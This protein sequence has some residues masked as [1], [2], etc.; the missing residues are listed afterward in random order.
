V[1]AAVAQYLPI[2]VET[3]ITRGWETTR[4]QKRVIQQVVAE[5]PEQVDVDALIERLHLLDKI[6]AGE[7]QLERGEGIT[8]AAAKERLAQWLR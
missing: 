6:E 2:K 1:I 7:Q 5:L 3:A 4:V 8:H